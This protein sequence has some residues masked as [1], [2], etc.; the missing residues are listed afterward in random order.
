MSSFR[1][2][3]ELSLDGSKWQ[4]GLNRAESSV[5]AFSSSVGNRLAAAFSVGAIASLSKATIDWAGNLR[6]VSDA[7]GVNVEWLQKVGNA[8]KLAGGSVDDIGKFLGEMN[9]SREDAINNPGGKNAQALGRLGFSSGDIS[10]LSTQAF[11]DRIVKQ[12]A[13]GAT[14][15]LSNDVQE[16][17]GKSAR[18]LM[19]AF[20]TQFQ[21]DT[22]ILSEELI[23]QLDDIGD[24]FTSLG[25]ALKVSL[26][27]AIV[28]VA[29]K[30]QGFID[31]IQQLGSMLGGF[32]ANIGGNIAN[33][34]FGDTKGLSEAISK[35][36]DDAAQAAYEE[37]QRQSSRDAG[38]RSASDATKAARRSREG[39]APLF[40][41]S[42][43]NLGTQETT[44]AVAP[45]SDSLLK[46]GNFLGASG[47][48]NMTSI[49]QRTAKATESM[50]RKMTQV[51]DALRNW[52][53]DSITL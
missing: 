4:A 53:N 43:I 20:A 5:R 33:V 2:S 48:N 24:R 10:G 50:D 19:A 51:V 31:I 16:V 42:P 18:N 23:N 3:G 6:D 38:I 17:G 49:A 14:T 22:P 21:S 15:Q 46:V 34:K 36:L 47:A 8:A 1:V 11:F 7:L 32:F 28:W 39:S 9:K 29:D 30:I 44:K 52:A 25:T 35:S 37:S 12:F 27:P 13:N 26:A 45:Y 40:A 41:A